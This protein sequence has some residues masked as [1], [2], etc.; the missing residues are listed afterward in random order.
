MRACVRSRSHGR[1]RARVGSPPGGREAGRGWCQ[2]GFSPDS[3]LF[4]GAGFLESMA[5][6]LLL[7]AED[8][9]RTTADLTAEAQSAQRLYD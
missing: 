9:N 2:G 4:R 8:Y 7:L 6:P 3:W 5:G 1:A